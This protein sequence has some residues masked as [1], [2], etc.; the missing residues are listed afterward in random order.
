MTLGAW[1]AL[2][3]ADCI[4][5]APRLVEGLPPQLT[6]QRVALIDPGQ[7]VETIKQNNWQ[8]ICLA[9]SGDTGFYSGARRLLPLLDFCP[10]Q[11]LPGIASP[12]YFAA[13]LG[14][15][16]Q[17]FH[18]VSAHGN[19]GD[20][21]DP[22]A[23][24]RNHSQTFFLTGGTWSAQSLCAALVEGGM[25]Q[26]QVTVGE[27]LSYPGER[28][29]TGS[30]QELAGQVFDSLSVVLVSRQPDFAR[31]CCV[32]GVEDEQFIRGSA[33]MTK[34][35]VRTVSLAKLALEPHHC[36]WDV[37]AGTGSVGVEAALLCTH[38]QVHAVECQEDAFD[39]LLQNKAKFGVT[40]LFAHRGMAPQALEGLPKPHGVFIG[41]SK[42]NLLE[43][44]SAAL[45]RNPG[46][47]VVVNAIALETLHLAMECFERLGFADVEV[48]QLAVS[49][50]KNVGSYHMMMGQN[51]VYILSAW[52]PGHV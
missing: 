37:G 26:A 44:L 19:H 28:I 13:K 34:C 3:Q 16:W 25:G 36:L 40:N 51:P 6:G 10:V 32:P 17:S 9:F 38:G 27:N 14:L 1:Q 11:V 35:E 2:E 31:R 46:V 29:V 49:R 41:G 23:Q 20:G 30:A 7:I 39:L 21:L 5:G 47:R 8:A 4:I 52:G 42:G 15:P 33:P 24:V 22:A 50:A 18:L 12:Q 48:V 45:A 43:I